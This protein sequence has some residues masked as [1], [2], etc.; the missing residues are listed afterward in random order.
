V[1]DRAAAVGAHGW[2][3]IR[4]NLF[5]GVRLQQPAAIPLAAMGLLNPMIAGAAMGLL[6]AICG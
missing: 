1:A 4:M 3:T 2:R 6:V 5:W